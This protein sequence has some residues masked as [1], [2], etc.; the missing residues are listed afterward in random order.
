MRVAIIRRWMFKGEGAA[1]AGLMIPWEALALIARA[2][3]GF[4]AAG[5][6]PW[7]RLG[8]H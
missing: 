4:T 5:L 7:D 3:E 8:G 2:E 6:S 1:V